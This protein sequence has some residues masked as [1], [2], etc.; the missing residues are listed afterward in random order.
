MKALLPFLL[1]AAGGVGLYFFWR[2]RTAVAATTSTPQPGLTPTQRTALYRQA[3]DTSAQ[4]GCVSAGGT[5]TMSGT[6]INAVG[7]CQLPPAVAPAIPSESFGSCPDRASCQGEPIG[8]YTPAPPAAV[9]TPTVTVHA[10]PA[11]APLPLPAKSL[12]VVSGTH[13]YL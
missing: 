11:L 8:G 13:S 7:N 12:V 10:A 2:H 5:W 3:A 9:A 1:L 4:V 6:G